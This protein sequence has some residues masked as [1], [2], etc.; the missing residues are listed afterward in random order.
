MTEVD[1]ELGAPV[2]VGGAFPQG[3]RPRAAGDVNVLLLDTL[4]TG[5]KSVPRDDLKTVIDESYTA[6]DYRVLGG[7]TGYSMPATCGEVAKAPIPP[8]G[9]L[10]RSAIDL[11]SV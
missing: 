3:A 8:V 4:N 11:K 10:A 2:L 9:A 1:L 5:L 6:V 7:G